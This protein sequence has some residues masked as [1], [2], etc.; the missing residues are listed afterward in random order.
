V[1]EEL[2]L[3]FS[4]HYKGPLKSSLARSQHESPC[5]LGFTFHPKTFTQNHYCHAAI[6][7]GQSAPPPSGEV[8]SMIDL[9]VWS[10]GSRR[11]RATALR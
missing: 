6:A 1:K 10:T 11:W 5:W 2:S 3:C 4:H 8:A 7:G 9:H